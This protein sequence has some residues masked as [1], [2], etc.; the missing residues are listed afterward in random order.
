MEETHLMAGTAVVFVYALCAYWRRG[1]G[2]QK[3]GN[4]YACDIRYEAAVAGT[5][6]R[7]TRWRCCWWRSGAIVGVTKLLMFR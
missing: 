7:S 4:G 5:M 3:R 6:I 1:C 2:F